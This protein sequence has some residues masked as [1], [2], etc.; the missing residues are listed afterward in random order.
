MLEDVSNF[1]KTK[2]DVAEI[3]KVSNERRLSY[4]R[5]MERFL[6]EFQIYPKFVKEF[7]EIEFDTQLALLRAQKQFTEQ[8]FIA[9]YILMK[10]AGFPVVSIVQDRVTGFSSLYKKLGRVIEIKCPLEPVEEDFFKKFMDVFLTFYAY[11][12]AR[13]AMTVLYL[14]RAMYGETAIR[15]YVD[16]VKDE[17]PTSTLID[18]VTLLPHWDSVKGSHLP[19][20]ITLYPADVV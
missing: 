7:Q 3:D 2:S 14:A 9:Y 15:E 6:R 17:A 18:M 19:W 16:R 11:R 20:A 8:Q 5:E 4:S 10:A 13:G 1:S 12:H